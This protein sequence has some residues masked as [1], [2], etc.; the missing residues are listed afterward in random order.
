MLKHSDIQGT[1][2][3]PI[4]CLKNQNWISL[5]FT[6]LKLNWSH[7]YIPKNANKKS[8]ETKKWEKKDEHMKLFIF[9]RFK[10]LNYNF[11]I[12]KEKNL[13]YP[14]FYR[15]KCSLANFNSN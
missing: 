9:I 7:I 11:L 14:K 12:L 2:M 10:W 5:I 6:R 3:E 8:I 13:I 4:T 1:K 15:P